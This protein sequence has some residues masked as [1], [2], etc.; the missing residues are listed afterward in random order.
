MHGP[1]SFGG[2]VKLLA[3]QRRAVAI[4]LGVTVIGLSA[5]APAFAES[6]SAPPT[7]PDGPPVIVNPAAGGHAPPPIEAAGWIVVDADSGAV[8]ASR[9]A[10]IPRP[11]ASTMKVLTAYT[12]IPRLQPSSIYKAIQMDEDTYGSRVGIE[13]GAT[14]T[15]HD[16][17]NGL[18]LPSG[19]DAASALAN[20]Y[21]GWAPTLKLMNAEAVR[22]GAVHTHAV[23]PSGLDAPGQVSTPEDLAILF[24]AAMT[25][26]LFRAVVSQK[27]ADFPDAMPRQG[28]KRTSY[29]VE[30]QDRLLLHDYP[31][32][33]GGKSGYT[34]NAGRTFVGAAHRNGHTLIYSLMDTSLSTE[35]CARKLLD[36]G[37]ANVGLVEPVG[38]LP[39]AQPEASEPR[40]LPAAKY[41][42][43]GKLI[44]A[45]S[46]SAGGAAAPA[47]T[48]P[49]KA[50]AAKVAVANAAS[51]GSSQLALPWL[52]FAIVFFAATLI[53]LVIW[54][55]RATFGSH[56]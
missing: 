27:H 42:A 17:L 43:S 33:L 25:L 52:P 47:S 12:L 10:D 38:T 39:T 40:A 22:L 13:A 8:M 14:Y 6:S 23:N 51:G 28:K 9:A 37:F 26:P 53:L 35:D 56:R 32:I 21:G 54:R 41:T 18:L 55:V 24:R 3:V 15:V 30:S 49:T 11:Q 36:W 48:P 31:G 20:A 29:P 2:Y 1:I 45:P 34:T 44:S 16:L 19:N 5:V 4:G 50:A 46:R 7:F